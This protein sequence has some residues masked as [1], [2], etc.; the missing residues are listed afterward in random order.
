[1][2]MFNEIIN[3]IVSI[4]LDALSAIVLIGVGVLFAWIELKI[5]KN[6]NLAN[7]NLAKNELKDAVVQTVGALKQKFADVWKEANGG[8][9]TEEQAAKLRTELVDLALEKMSVASI[10]VLEAAKVDAIAYIQDEAEA[11]IERLN[12]ASGELLAIG[13][14]ISTENGE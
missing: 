5:G 3:E 14:V 13:E 4:G 6:K 9:L 12:N 11:F 2:K 7:I 1:M 10:K 8:K